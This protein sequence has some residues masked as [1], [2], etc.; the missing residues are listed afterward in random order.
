[1]YFT[2][3]LKVHVLHVLPDEVVFKIKIVLTL[4]AQIQMILYVLLNW[5]H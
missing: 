2:N 4:K 3:L 5:T 1:M